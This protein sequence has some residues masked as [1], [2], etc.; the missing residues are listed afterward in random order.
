MTVACYWRKIILPSVPEVHLVLGVPES[1]WFPKINTKTSRES[2]K[3][4]VWTCEKAETVRWLIK[5]HSK[6]WTAQTKVNVKA[7]DSSTSLTATNS[8]LTPSDLQVPLHPSAPVH[9]TQ[10]DEHDI[11]NSFYSSMAGITNIWN[12]FIF[13]KAQ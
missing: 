13:K 12:C 10:E 9:P 11:R 4:S 5:V 7:T 6:L 1:H 8:P 3:K 2:K